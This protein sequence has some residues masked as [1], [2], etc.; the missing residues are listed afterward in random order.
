MPAHRSIFIA[1]SAA[2]LILSSSWTIGTA[3]GDSP[4]AAEATTA[5]PKAAA[6]RVADTVK[7]AV[8]DT[9]KGVMDGTLEDKMSEAVT[10]A[11][12]EPTDEG[13]SQLKLVLRVLKEFIHQHAP[14]AVDHVAPVD[15]CLFGS[16]VTGTAFTRGQPALTVDT[17][18]G[19][20]VVT[21]HF[22]GVTTTRTVAVKHPVKAFNTGVAVFDVHRPIHFDG[23]Q[24]TDGPETIEATYTSRLDG[25]STP[26]G[27]RGR[28]VRRFATP[29]IEA[30]KPKAD[31][32]A[33]AD[34]KTSV[35]EAFG[36]HSDELVGDLNARLPWK[37]TLALLMPQQSQVVGHFSTTKDWVMISPGPKDAAMPDLPEEA[38]EM[39]APVELWVHG[40]PGEIPATQL[41]ALWSAV[42]VGLGEFRDPAATV[43]ENIKDI[44]PAMVDDWWVIRVGTDLIES[45]IDQMKK[46][47]EGR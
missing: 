35:L 15:K 25:L 32:I 2:I 37:Q 30:M 10:G 41:V 40:K 26:P 5:A 47:A 9:V 8:T 28:I 44:Q 39:R 14:P 22:K 21:L 11:L 1:S 4:P 42:H 46:E 34:T 38:A 31:A 19:K 3:A 13:S 24:F 6:E 36:K 16:R 20:P 23:V 29:Q 43:A 33:L 18:H 17:A 45:M 7:D 27:L 12:A